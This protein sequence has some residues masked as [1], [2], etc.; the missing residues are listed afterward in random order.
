MRPMSK[1]SHRTLVGQ[2]GKSSH[3][4]S[5]PLRLADISP[6]D[7]FQVYALS[8]DQNILGGNLWWI[9]M[10]G[11]SVVSAFVALLVE[12]NSRSSS[13]FEM[14]ALSESGETAGAAKRDDQEV[15]K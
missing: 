7:V 1:P 12:D 14:S 9:F 3:V 10:S 11:V 15:Q 6:Y 5:K 13:T 8:I 4:P 2:L